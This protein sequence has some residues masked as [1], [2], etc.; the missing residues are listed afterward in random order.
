MEW[1][2]LYKKIVLLFLL[3]F[4]IGN[5][6]AFTTN[7]DD[8]FSSGNY[9]NNW[10]VI[11]GGGFS[12]A[13]EVLQHDSGTS[14]T[15][16]QE[17]RTTDAD[18]N[19]TVNWNDW[20]FSFKQKTNVFDPAN[21]EQIVIM[22]SSSTTVFI[23]RW[24]SSDYK[25]RL[26]IVGVGDVITSTDVFSSTGTWYDVK[27]TKIDT[28]MILY[29]DD[30]YQGS[31]TYS[32]YKDMNKISWSANWGVGIGGTPYRGLKFRD[33]FLLKSNVF[34]GSPF[35]ISINEPSTGDQV[36]GTTDLNVTV[37]DRNQSLT[38][39]LKVYYSATAGNYDN[40][41][42]SDTNLWDGVGFVCDSYDFSIAQN[43]VYQ[44]D[45]TS[46]AD[47]NYFID[48]NIYNADYN[49]LASGGEFE[50][51][52]NQIDANF[53]WV[54]EETNSRIYLYDTTI[55]NNVTLN[56]WDWYADGIKKS[57]LN[58]YYQGTQA[59]QD[60]NICLYVAGIGLDSIT[61][62]DYICQSVRTWDTIT[63]TIDVNIDTDAFGFVTDFGVDYNMACYDNFTPI[64]YDVN[65]TYNGTTTNIYSSSDANASIHSGSLDL[66]IGQSV[67]LTFTCTDSYGNFVT[68]DSNQFYALQFY[69][70]DEDTG[71]YFD[72][73]N[74]VTARA[75]TYDGTHEYDFK[76]TNTVTKNFFSDSQ[77]VQFE[78]VYD[79]LSQT[80]IHRDIDFRY[81][82]DENIPVCV[83]EPQ[84]FYEQRFLSKST[85]AVLLKNTFANCYNMI[86]TTK[87]LYGTKLMARAF[88][89]N[90][91]Y[92]YA[93][94]AGTTIAYI[95]GSK[96]SEI[97]LDVLKYNTTTYELDILG[98]SIG[99]APVF[100]S[101]TGEYDANVVRWFYQDLSGVSTRTTLGVYKNNVLLWSYTETSDPNEFQTT[102]YYGDLNLTVD[103]FLVI[104]V[105][106]TTTE[107]SVTVERTFTLSG[108]QFSGVINEVVAVVL[109]MILLVFGLTI[110]SYKQTFGWFGLLI[111]G[112]ALIILALAPWY[113]YIQFLIGI[114]I[115]LMVF[116]ALVAK[117]ETG[118]II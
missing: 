72:L 86:A 6:F 93:S 41:I 90:K 69:L 16:G 1:I 56:D 38:P 68:T 59:N 62:S 57:D 26:N 108:T 9:T 111:E 7:F 25:L 58:A 99:F 18:F 63:P 17:I 39:M 28:N 109:A 22:D 78:F 4:L 32:G 67:Y 47:G 12:V 61:Y 74:V 87:D 84:T 27:L 107:G 89:V 114:T 43:C 96:E 115:I 15:G 73:N 104:K 60:L 95:D 118:G 21:G 48:A 46:V 94:T 92:T 45:T 116:T 64:Q 82:P 42:Y 88:T 44:W 29:V 2:A 8:D 33:D 19:G 20:E 55:S 105:T 40:L 80:R 75:F 66:N 71:E 36:V 37:T 85:Q 106:K 14:N 30:V 113:W 13:G 50:I 5:A 10:T 100:N 112:M 81:A 102:M 79:D 34:I 35:S 54:L 24:N 3:L 117:Q 65:Y 70:I 11:Q 110:T 76:D 51:N 97:D 31:Y 91:P 101:T 83:A 98:T 53:D 49:T 103:D 77:V 52:N 23:L